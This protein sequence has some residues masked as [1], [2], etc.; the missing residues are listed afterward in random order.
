ML[1]TAVNGKPEEEAGGWAMDEK[2][3]VLLWQCGKKPK[4]FKKY[5]S[6][7]FQNMNSSTLAFSSV[8]TVN[9]LNKSTYLG[10]LKKMIL[11]S[12]DFAE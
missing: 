5:N 8:W 1:D 9:F 7:D 2:G 11:N 10:L 4:G 3:F 6:K 12:E